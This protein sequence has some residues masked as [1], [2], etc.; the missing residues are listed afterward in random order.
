MPRVSK[1]DIENSLKVI[2]KNQISEGRKG[3]VKARK[4]PEARSSLKM[5]HKFESRYSISESPDAAQ[6]NQLQIK[7]QRIKLVKAGSDGSSL[8]QPGQISRTP[9]ISSGPKQASSA[10]A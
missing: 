1:E 6:T 3:S 9:D 7:L 4:A 10:A 5:L 8:Q 2:N